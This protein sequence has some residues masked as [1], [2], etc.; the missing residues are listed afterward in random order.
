[1]SEPSFLTICAHTGECIS[2]PFSKLVDKTLS[3]LP[4]LWLCMWMCPC[5]LTYNFLLAFYPFNNKFVFS[6]INPISLFLS[7][8]R[9]VGFGKD[10]WSAALNSDSSGWNWIKL[11][12]CPFS[13]EKGQQAVR[14]E[15]IPRLKSPPS[16]HLLL[17]WEI[18][19]DRNRPALWPLISGH[20][21]LNCKPIETHLEQLYL[22]FLKHC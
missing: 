16:E 18:D 6:A 15:A 5:F 14:A 22:W 19:I 20:K 8:I 3:Y 9:W 7:D 4:Y 13:A 12:A 21:T 2:F 10:G 11:E 17:V 1:M